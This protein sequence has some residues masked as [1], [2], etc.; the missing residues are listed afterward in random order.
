MT[1]PCPDCHGSCVQLA[2]CS[3]CNG[4]GTV[5]DDSCPFCG[6]E[7]AGPVERDIVCPKCDGEG[8]EEL[9]CE[10]C[11]S[12]GEVEAENHEDVKANG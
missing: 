12:Y 9:G 1:I 2:A 10:Y 5:P 11:D 7:Y 4:D 6:G 3:E 8:I